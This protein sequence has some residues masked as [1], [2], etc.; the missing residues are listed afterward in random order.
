LGLEV[1]DL[2]KDPNAAGTLARSTTQVF[3]LEKALGFVSKIKRKV[4]T[5]I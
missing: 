1:V 2:A 4:D 3:N 5:P